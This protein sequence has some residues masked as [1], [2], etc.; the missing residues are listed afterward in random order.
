MTCAS[1]NY[2]LDKPTWEEYTEK[3]SRKFCPCAR[4]SPKYLL[5]IGSAYGRIVV[6]IDFP[7][8]RHNPISRLFSLHCRWKFQRLYFDTLALLVGM[9]ESRFEENAKD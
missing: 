6:S 1:S 2:F 9:M 4:S 3:N 8:C 7:P 5:T